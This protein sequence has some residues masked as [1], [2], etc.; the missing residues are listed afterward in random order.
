MT[1]QIYEI[2]KNG[3][4]QSRFYENRSAAQNYINRLNHSH[5]TSAMYSA[6]RMSAAIKGRNSERFQTLIE[7]VVDLPYVIQVRQLNK[8]WR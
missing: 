1:K 6:N 5:I 8:E 7:S 2:V 4:S 3:V